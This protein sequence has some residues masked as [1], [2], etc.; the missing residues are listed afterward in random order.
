MTNPHIPVS[1]VLP[2]VIDGYDFAAETSRALREIPE[3]C[4]GGHSLHRGSARVTFSGETP[5]DEAVRREHKASIFQTTVDPDSPVIELGWPTH[6]HYVQDSRGVHMDLYLGVAQKLVDEHHP[7]LQR[8]VQ[9]L[10]EH[11]LILRR[12]IN[13]DDYLR[14]AAHAEGIHTP[15]ALAAMIDGAASQAYGGSWRTFFTNSGTESIEACLKLAFEVKY[16]RFLAQHGADTLA[17]LMAELGIKEFTPLAGDKSRPEPVYEDYPFFIVGCLDAF[18]GRT[19]GSLS[20]TA[21]KKAQKLGF[22]RSRWVRHIVANQVGA[23]GALI[24]PTP[25]ATLLATPGALRASIDAGRV[26]ADLFAAFLV[27]PLRGEGGYV[28]C[29]PE[30]LKDCETVSHAHGGLLILDEVQ[31]FGRSGTLFLGE[32]MGVVPDAMA[33]AKGLFTAAMVA[34]ADLDQYLHTGWHSNTWGGG[35][36]FDN[37]IGYAVLD[38]MLHEKSPVFLGRTYPENLRLKGKLLEAG[39]AELQRR[40]PTIVDS[41]MVKGGLSRLSVRRRTDLIHAGWRRGLKLLGCGRSGEVSSIRTLFLA[42]VLAKE[43]HEAL[44]LLDAAM[45]DV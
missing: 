32:Q 29:T 35:K 3:V 21:S 2:Q 10:L 33:L 26:P 45:S 4:F 17:K 44:D 42:D 20:I 39:F 5:A 1:A 16:K 31:T 15:Q 30:F 12:E 41:F 7:A 24:D 28:L 27:E 43:I 14:V 8:A 11:G 34:R 40:H 19:L 18:H 36:I 25:L 13:T 22:P 6:G 9:K 37:Q 23:L 38:I